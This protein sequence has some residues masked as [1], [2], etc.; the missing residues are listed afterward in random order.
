MHK[1][2]KIVTLGCPKNEVDSEQ[3]KGLLS[4]AGFS[5]V[6]QAADAEIIIVNSCGFIESA[7]Q[8]SIDTILELARL[9]KEG[10]C[11]LLVMAGCMV[12][13]YSAELKEALPEVDIFV[14]TGDWPELPCLL[15]TREPAGQKIVVTQPEKYLYEDSISRDYPYSKAYAYV[16]IAEGCNN[17]CTYCV[18]PQLKGAYRSRSIASIVREVE[19]LTANGVKEIVLIAQDTTSYGLD[20]AGQSLLP[21]LLQGTMPDPRGGM[22]AF[23]LLLSGLSYR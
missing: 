4:K 11:Q 6:D 3:M 15:S 7:K 12:Q 2:F 20:L 8:E 5:A 1:H 21:Q 22:A 18:I 19:D 16:K 9:K 10:Q 14:G 23:A 13:K 17:C